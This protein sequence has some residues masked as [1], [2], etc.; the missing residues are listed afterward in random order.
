MS[1][2]SLKNSISCA[3]IEFIRWIVD[4][5]MIIVLCLCIFIYSFAVEPIKANAELMG[6]P[7]NALEPFI[8]VLNSGMLLL[9]IPLGFITLISDYPQINSSTIFYIFRIGKKSW[10]CGQILRLILMT[11]TYVL[12]IF[13]SSVVGVI[14][15]GFAGEEWSL[16]ATKFSSEFPE[17]SGNFGVLLL[18]ENLYNQMSLPMAVAEST[19]FVFAYLF[20]L[21]MILLAFSIAKRKTAGIIVCGFLISLGAALCSI[22]SNLMWAFP[23]A[24]SIVW[25]HYTKFLREPIFPVFYSAVYFA[26][27]I[28]VSLIFCTVSI[29]RFNYDA[30]SSEV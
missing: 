23:M 10:L 22:N 19:L 14:T 17:Q 2:F 29:K 24:H 4:A 7:M 1:K 9:I 13:I 5:K 3:Y 8:A 20:S 28:I 21:G 15:T 26:A 12:A 16:V 27:I 18:P 25:L 6:E 11:T 30:I